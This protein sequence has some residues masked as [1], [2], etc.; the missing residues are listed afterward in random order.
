MTDS[1]KP[2]SVPLIFEEPEAGLE[3]RDMGFMED[4]EVLT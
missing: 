4:S 1:H 2:N 3:A